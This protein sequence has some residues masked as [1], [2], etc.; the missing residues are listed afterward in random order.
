V[1]LV[2]TGANGFVGRQVVALAAGE[3]IEVTGLVRSDAAAERV[4]R[5]GGRPAR[6]SGFDDPALAQWST[7]PRPAQI[8]PAPRSTTSTSSALGA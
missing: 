4:S 2:V 1:R 3:G 7:W 6:V 8:A 5:A